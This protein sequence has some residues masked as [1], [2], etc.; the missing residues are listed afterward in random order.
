[1]EIASRCGDH[2]F[3]VSSLNM[4]MLVRIV[5]GTFFV[6]S[7]VFA[8]SSD[9]R[10]IQQGYADRMTKRFRDRGVDAIA[11]VSQDS[12]VI[13]SP[14]MQPKPVRDEAMRQMFDPASRKALCI[15]GFKTVNIKTKAIFG[16]GDL[17][18]LGCAKTEE[19]KTTDKS[20]RQ[21]YLAGLERA[22][23][24]GTT[25]VEENG[26]AVFTSPKFRDF[27]RTQIQALVDAGN[28]CDM[29]FSGVRFRSGPASV[30]TYIRCR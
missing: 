18:S 29:G 25:V 20:K 21:E 26:I 7:A 4:R 23:G 27:N 6:A 28:V 19:E 5:L 10:V 30:G 16:D 14:E 12:L 2:S 24:E 11:V 3:A 17:Y 9:K 22:F 8:Q 13:V 1:M 15:M